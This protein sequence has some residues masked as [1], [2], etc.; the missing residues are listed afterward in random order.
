MN[1][2]GRQAEVVQVKPKGGSIWSQGNGMYTQRSQETIMTV[3]Q[4]E[5][6]S[7]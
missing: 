6:E 7:I 4:R 2:P 5:Q 1:R 3:K